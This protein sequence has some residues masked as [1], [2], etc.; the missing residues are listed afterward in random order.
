M[1]SFIIVVIIVTAIITNERHGSILVIKVFRAGGDGENRWV[2]QS[3]EDMLA[4]GRQ[5]KAGVL[6]VFA[7]SVRLS[8]DEEPGWFDGSQALPGGLVERS[9]NLLVPPKFLESSSASVSRS[10]MENA[11]EGLGIKR[12][13]ELARE[14]KIVRITLVADV[15]G[16]NLRNVLDLVS[17]AKKLNAEIK[18]AGGKGR[19]CITI[20]LCL[21]H[22]LHRCFRRIFDTTRHLSEFHCIHTRLQI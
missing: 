21:A 14:G 16:T 9:E 2:V 12:L 18:A 3:Y 13:F 11:V 20:I 17:A 15:A 5:T 1:F 7:Q 6:D 4:A 22:V 19:V 8:W 10:A